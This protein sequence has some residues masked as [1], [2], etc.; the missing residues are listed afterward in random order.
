M[1][2]PSPVLV[3]QALESSKPSRDLLRGALAVATG[4]GESGSAEGK[5]VPGG[6]MGIAVL[7]MRTGLTAAEVTASIRV[8]R[9]TGLLTER[10]DRFWLDPDLY[11]TLPALGEMD[12]AGAR[13]GIERV[14]G[15][16]A[17]ALALL[18]ELARQSRRKEDGGAEWLQPVMQEL[19]DDMVYGRTAA[20]QALK[21]LAQAG[22]VVKADLPARRGLRIRLAAQAFD[23]EA[24]SGET[25]P[26]R[27]VESWGQ[28]IAVQIGGATIGV[29][30]GTR[31]DLPAGMNYRLE[32]APDG[33]AIIRVND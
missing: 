30:A 3:R 32:I 7:A 4:L 21:D 29:P 27:A 16:L 31:L 25:T 6:S 18:R 17:P 23:G 24:V 26:A 14:G 1:R 5:A 12:W 22:L 28:G 15:R 19:V 20:T 13:R 8:L 11:C 10:Q 2:V 33:R 9:E